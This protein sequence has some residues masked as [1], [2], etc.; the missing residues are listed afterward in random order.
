[1]T[2]HQAVQCMAEQQV[3]A[4]V[5]TNPAGTAVG[6][7]T[8]RDYLL[9]VGLFCHDSQKTLL[10]DVMTTPVETASPDATVEDALSRMIRRRFRHLPIVD[11]DQ[12]PIAIVSIRHLLMRRLGEKQASLEILDALAGAGGP[13]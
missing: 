1:M 3:G 2:V 5:V 13:G 9:R 4:V 8:E 11:V 6:I 12:R 7:F 10:S